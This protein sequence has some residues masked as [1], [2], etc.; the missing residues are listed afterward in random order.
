MKQYLFA[1]A[2]SFGAGKD[3][4]GEEGSLSEGGPV[5]VIEE[6]RV[7]GLYFE[8]AEYFEEEEFEG[9]GCELGRFVE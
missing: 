8:E 6:E 9:S 5:V 1:G 4:L 3:D 7:D 2:D